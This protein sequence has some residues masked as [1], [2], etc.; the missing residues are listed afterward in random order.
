MRNP[1]LVTAILITYNRPLLLKESVEALQRQTHANLEI[2]LINNGGTEKTTE[3][4]NQVAESDLRVKLMRYQEN[5][6][7]LDDHQ[8]YIRICLNDALQKSTGDYVWFNADDDFIADDYLEK[9]VALF[10]GNPECTTAAGIPVSVDID[11]KVIDRRPRTTNIR[12]RY[13]PGHEMI[14]RSMRGDRS[15]FSSPGYNFTVRRDVIVDSGGYHPSIENGERYGIV[16]FGVTGFDETAYFYF[17]RHT[18]Q[19]HEELNSDGRIGIDENLALISDWDLEERWK[20]F[21]DPVAR[22]VV[23]AIEMNTCVA[24]ASWFI[25]LLYSWK[26]QGAMRIFRKMW[27]RRQFWVQVPKSALEPQWLKQLIRVPVRATGK[28]FLRVIFRLLP[29]IASISPRMYGLRQR[30]NHKG[31][32]RQ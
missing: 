25:R 26:I 9:M 31:Y 3:Y 14:L 17:R 16:P 2:I 12:P 1:H 7:S 18:G 32:D 20:V 21:G 13:M 29:L 27:K 8:K 11:G 6:W 15:I 23:T 10:E 30:I 22:E 19:W 28:L 4:L 24:A 5:Q